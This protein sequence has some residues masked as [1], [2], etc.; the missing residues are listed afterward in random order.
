M[1]ISW[2]EKRVRRNVDNLFSVVHGNVETK[3]HVKKG[4][5]DLKQLDFFPVDVQTRLM[6]LQEWR[7][8]LARTRGI[9]PYRIFNNRTL[10]HLATRNPQCAQE[11]SQING[12]KEKR[13]QDYGEELL[14][15]LKKPQHP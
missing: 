1:I 8:N 5:I 13:M 14:T 3:V 10:V 2:F 12:I 15:F 11:L 9:P 7:K 6:E 4:G